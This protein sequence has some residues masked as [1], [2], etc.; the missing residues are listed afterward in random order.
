[1]DY[2]M[3]KLNATDIFP[4]LN[5]ISKIGLKNIKTLINDG[6]VEAIVHSVKPKSGQN[7]KG[8]TK[9]SYDLEKVG[10]S[11]FLELGDIVCSNIMKCQNDIFEFFASLCE[12]DIDKL[13]NLGMEEF[14][15]LIIQFV[16]KEELKD[17][18]KVVS[19]FL[20]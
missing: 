11:L 17:F 14:V 12:V 4:M 3:R 20:N 2:K 8:E 5:I 13:K 9:G 18:M 16:Q 1:M 15:V 7:E 10:L 6:T 19:K